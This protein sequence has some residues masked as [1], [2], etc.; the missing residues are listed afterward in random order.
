[1]RTISFTLPKWNI[2]ELT[3][4][5]PQ[6]TFWQDFSIADKFGEEAV[7]DTYNRA[8]KEWKNNYVYLTELA[9]VLNHKIWQHYESND[10][11]ASIYDNLWRQVDSYACENLKGAE[12]DYYL[13]TTD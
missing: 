4:Y 11:L 9:M 5:K 13:S 8:F 7:K 12:M 10:A 1:M 2:E 6:T 3:G